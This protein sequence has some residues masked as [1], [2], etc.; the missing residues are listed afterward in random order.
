MATQVT[1]SPLAQ[2]VPNVAAPACS[3][4]TS[5]LKSDGADDLVNHCYA[6][7]YSKASNNGS[8][9]ASTH[10]QTEDSNTLSDL[11]KILHRVLGGFVISPFSSI[12]SV[13]PSPLSVAAA[14]Q[15]TLERTLWLSE[16]SPLSSA[17]SCEALRQIFSICDHVVNQQKIGEPL[18][19]EVTNVL[20]L[21]YQAV[22]TLGRLREIQSPPILHDTIEAIVFGRSLPLSA[23]SS[24]TT[25]LQAL[26]FLCAAILV[27]V[28]PMP[29]GPP[30]NSDDPTGGLTAEE[31]GLN[32]HSFIAPG[33][34][35]RTPS[36]ILGLRNSM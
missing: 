19:V 2:Q 24:T 26:R 36:S 20:P 12:N 35:P 3:S 6:M 28:E 17:P 29:F 14:G 27:A 11:R 8:Q 18:G 16:G 23:S 34:R 30:A 33:Y 10:A 31:H 7:G 9:N 25:Q 22:E 13:D 1:A 5:S 15:A 4:V 32:Y 21:G